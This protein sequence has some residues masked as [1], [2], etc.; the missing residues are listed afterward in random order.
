VAPAPAAWLLAPA[1]AADRALKTTH[2][3]AHPRRAAAD[4]SRGRKLCV[5]FVETD[6]ERI[7]VANTLAIG[8]C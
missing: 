4:R 6:S 3:I 5:L 8:H 2:R 1:L 7:Y